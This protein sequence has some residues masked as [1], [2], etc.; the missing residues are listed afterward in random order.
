MATTIS[1]D[2]RIFYFPMDLHL[3]L[4]EI[5]DVVSTS[6]GCSLFKN[7]CL[8]NSYHPYIMFD[9]RFQ[10]FRVLVVVS[11]LFHGFEV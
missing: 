3:S 11:V 4:M 9:I 10:F 1:F 5:F 6:S 2:M 8:G 7:S